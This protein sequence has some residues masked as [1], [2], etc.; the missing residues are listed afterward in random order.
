[1]ADLTKL[2]KLEALKQLAERVRDDYVAN[3]DFEVAKGRVTKLEGDVSGLQ[4]QVGALETASGDYAKSADVE[5]DYL[6]KTE[7]ASTYL[8]QEEAGETYLEK[9]EAASTYLTQTSAA[10]TYATKAD[11]SSV[12]RPAG[13]KSSVEILETPSASILGNVYNMTAAFI[14]DSKFIDDEVGN[15]YPK[16]TNVVVIDA[17]EEDYKYDVL[18]GFVDLT[19]YEKTADMEEYV[20][21]ELAGYYDKDAIDGM[22]AT[23][24]EVDE[25]LNGVFGTADVE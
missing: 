14:A 7:A 11:V 21:G 13:S 6:K 20:E 25:M 23:S 16:G 3:E 4:E 19:D 17:G 12:Y 9:T 18:S 22:I 1:M 10:S 5:R 2:T 24:T 8:E 15:K